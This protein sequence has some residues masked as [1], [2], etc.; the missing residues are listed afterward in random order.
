MEENPAAILI[1]SFSHYLPGFIH[2]LWCRIS[3]PPT[4]NSIFSMGSFIFCQEIWVIAKIR[5][6][7]FTVFFC[8][9]HLRGMTFF[10][11]EN[12]GKSQNPTVFV[13]SFFF[14]C[15]PFCIVV[16]LGGHPS[17]SHSLVLQ[18]EIS[19]SPA[20]LKSQKPYPFCGVLLFVTQCHDD[21]TVDSHGCW[22]YCLWAF[23]GSIGAVS[24][25]GETG[26]DVAIC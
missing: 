16:F 9:E 24:E 25:T 13:Q 10:E 15:S 20:Y 12:I 4:I 23:V 14:T 18:N 17:T 8:T 2:P 26:E 7:F 6:V 3:E 19:T 21:S 1:G 22:L 11:L 5:T